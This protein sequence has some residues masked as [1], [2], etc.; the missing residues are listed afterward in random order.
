MRATI[1][2]ESALVNFKGLSVRNLPMAK[3]RYTR[4]GLLAIDFGRRC[5][6]VDVPLLH[7]SFKY[8]SKKETSSEGAQAIGGLSGTATGVSMAHT[9]Y[10]GTDHCQ[11]VRTP[12]ADTGCAKIRFFLLPVQI[13]RV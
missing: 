10:C 5:A 13:M 7:V 2:I 3:P 9:L 8:S 6:G 4:Y 1:Q 11:P 12:R